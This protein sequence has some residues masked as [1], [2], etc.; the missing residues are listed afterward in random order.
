ML[1]TESAGRAGKR[2]VPNMSKASDTGIKTSTAIKSIGCSLLKLLIE[3]NQLII[4]DAN[5]IEEL[6]TFSKKGKSYEAEVGKH[7]DLVM[8]LVLFAWMTSQGYFKEISNINTLMNLRTKNKEDLYS[9]LT[10]FGLYDEGNTIG[11]GIV[12]IGS[13]NIDKWLT[14]D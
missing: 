3:Q 14:S 6:S 2:I 12:D 9:E 13:M 8:C 11:D 10:L 4:K 1:F 7:D 5:T